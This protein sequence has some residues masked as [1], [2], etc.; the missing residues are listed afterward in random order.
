MR[1]LEDARHSPLKYGILY[2]PCPKCKADIKEGV[3]VCPS[4]GYVLPRRCPDCGAL[5]ENEKAKFCPECGI[6]LIKRCPNCNQE[7]AGTPKFCPECEQSYKMES[8]DYKTSS[9]TS[10]EW[11]LSWPFIVVILLLFWPVGI[12]LIWK[13]NTVSKKT[14]MSLGKVLW[15]VGWC[16][17]VFGL[18]QHFLLRMRDS[19]N[20]NDTRNA[21]TAP[22]SKY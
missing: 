16:V 18:L 15:I 21:G 14:A 5:I 10:L 9:K 13:R 1:L 8:R 19:V 7:I 3:A 6:T 22:A 12:F 2:N 20:E 17:L 4:C 11:W